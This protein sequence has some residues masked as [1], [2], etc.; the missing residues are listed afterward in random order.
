MYWPE[1]LP[2]SINGVILCSSSIASLLIAARRITCTA[3]ISWVTS[4]TVFTFNSHLM[5]VSFPQTSMNIQI[6][7]LSPQFS[8]SIPFVTL[9]L[10]S[11][12][13]QN[14][15]FLP[16]LV[17]S[18]NNYFQ[19]HHQISSLGSFCFASVTGMTRWGIS[20]GVWDSLVERKLLHVWSN[21][22]I[23]LL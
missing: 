22:I 20:W 12:C 21:L 15:V 9:T 4:M 2:I 11:L 23:H 17:K 16:C 3:E 7:F 19:L 10:F 5:H 18:K 13:T 8:P 1:F 6:M 14:Q